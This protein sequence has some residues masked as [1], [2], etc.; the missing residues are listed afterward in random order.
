MERAELMRDQ[1]HAFG[2]DWRIPRCQG[3]VMRGHSARGAR[4]PCFTRNK[5]AYT[6]RMSRRM[7][8]IPPISHDMP[9]TPTR[10]IISETGQPLSRRIIKGL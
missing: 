5:F 7:K 10:M 1:I 9:P 2:R 4:I 8:T 6:V 3:S